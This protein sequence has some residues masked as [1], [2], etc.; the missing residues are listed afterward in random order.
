[1]VIFCPTQ[2]PVLSYPVLSYNDISH[3]RVVALV[4]SQRAAGGEGSLRRCALPKMKVR[5]AFGCGGREATLRNSIRRP[6]GP[7]SA[8]KC[9]RRSRTRERAIGTPAPGY[10][11]QTCSRQPASGEGRRG[12]IQQTP[13]TE[14]RRTAT[15]R[16]RCNRRR[17]E[18]QLHA[19]LDLTR[20]LVQRSHG[21]EA[22]LY[23]LASER[24]TSERGRQWG[25]EQSVRIAEISV[26][27]HVE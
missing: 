26:I 11:T 12:G 5:R 10:R 8:A 18:F 25:R 19:E 15:M 7:S 23:A 20:R 13:G 17:L 22:G 9:D 3:R 14:T 6:F 21:R 24:G 4:F 16:P 1:M 2:S 27:Q